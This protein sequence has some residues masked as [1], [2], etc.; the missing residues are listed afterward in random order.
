MILVHVGQCGNQIGR[1]FWNL[2]SP[3]LPLPNPYHRSSSPRPLGGSGEAKKLKKTRI[4]AAAG[5]SLAI[6]VDSEPKVNG[7]GNPKGTLVNRSLESVRREAERCDVFQGCFL[8]S[9]LCGGTGS[10]L[11]SRLVEELRDDYPRRCILSSMVAPFS[12]GELPLQHY[13]TM[14]CINSHQKASDGII[15][16]QNDMVLKVLESSSPDRNPNLGFQDINQCIAQTLDDLI[17]PSLSPHRR[18]RAVTRFFKSVSARVSEK[19]LRGFEMREFVGSV[20]PL[21]SAKLV[22]LWSSK[23][24]RVLDKNKTSITW[25]GEIEMLLKA[26]RNTDS[27]QRSCL[28]YQLQLTG[29]PHALRKFKPQQSMSSITRRLKCVK[30]NPYPGDLKLI[31]RPVSREGRNQTGLLSVNR[32]ALAGYLEGV[33]KKAEDMLDVGAY[34][35]W[36]IKHGLEEGELS[37]AIETV[38]RIIDDYNSLRR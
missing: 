13:N 37:G 7:G 15:L 8:W 23:G 16:F 1:E 38:Q 18:S 32:T 17:S 31:S 34:K 10:G 35:H 36:Y 24:L 11:G 25:G 26:T 4:L 22:E 28:G 19:R 12:R 30:W 3:P 27:R 2:Q 20:C 14:L 5:N 21:P 29:P 9:S 6:L 33:K